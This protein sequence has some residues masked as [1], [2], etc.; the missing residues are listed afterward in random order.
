MTPDRHENTPKEDY[1]GA[2]RYGPVFSITPSGRETVLHNFGASSGDGEY[3][4]AGL[5]N[6][7]GSA[8]RPQ[9][10]ARTAVQADGGGI[11]DAG[12]VFSLSP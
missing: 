10:G 6:V 2:N 4:A 9:T 5:I 8:A 12:T 1:G 3:Q 7:N 11:N